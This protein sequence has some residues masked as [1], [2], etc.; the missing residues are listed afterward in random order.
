MTG[1]SSG[2]LKIPVVTTLPCQFTSLGNPTLTDTIFMILHTAQE[3]LRSLALQR[4]GEWMQFRGHTPG[5]YRRI[6]F[7]KFSGHCFI[8]GLENCDPKRLV[9]GFTRPAG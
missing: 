4:H 5:Y 3:A 6:A 1:P 9:A 8:V 2:S 7:H